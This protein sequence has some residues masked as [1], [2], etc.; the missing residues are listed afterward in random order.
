MKITLWDTRIE[1]DNL[2]DGVI[3]DAIEAV[4]AEVRMR[5]EYPRVAHAL[6]SSVEA[7]PLAGFVGQ[8]CDSLRNRLASVHGHARSLYEMVVAQ[9]S[10]S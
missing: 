4:I 7:G 10:P 3:M 6:S 5:N 9:N 8:E 1:S 2:G